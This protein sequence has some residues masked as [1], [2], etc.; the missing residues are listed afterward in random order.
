MLTVPRIEPF[1]LR[2]Q[3]HQGW[4]HTG[5]NIGEDAFQNDRTKPRVEPCDLKKGED[6]RDACQSCLAAQYVFDIVWNQVPDFETL[7]FLVDLGR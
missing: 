6:S 4:R 1:G 3:A 2:V 5:E 7:I